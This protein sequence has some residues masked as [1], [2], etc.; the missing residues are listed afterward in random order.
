M[1]RAGVR[2]YS[3]TTTWPLALTFDAGLFGV[4]QVTVG[5]PAGRDQQRVAA[6]TSNRRC[7]GISTPSPSCRRP[8]T[9]WWLRISHFLEAMSVKRIA[10]VVVVAAQ[11]RAAAD[12]QRDAAA[13]RREDVGELACDET[14][15]DDDQ[16]F[17]HVERSA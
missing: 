5:H 14:A 3:S 9:S 1:P 2:W 13:Q 7:N 11:Q 17:G 6:H 8:A 12:H 10:D 15:A 4:E 16:V